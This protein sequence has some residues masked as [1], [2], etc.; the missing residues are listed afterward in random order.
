MTLRIKLWGLLPS[1]AAM[2][3]ALP[4][5]IVPQADGLS[6]QEGLSHAAF[7]MSY[8]H[9]GRLLIETNKTHTAHMDRG[10]GTHSLCARNSF[11]GPL[12]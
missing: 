4:F 5:D 6:V 12:I 11:L 9:S 7:K 2:A 1:K 8:L 3:L 10:K